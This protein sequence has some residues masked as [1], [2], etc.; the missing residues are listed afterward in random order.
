MARLKDLHHV[1]PFFST[2]AGGAPNSAYAGMGETDGV[3]ASTN[4]PG[5]QDFLGTISTMQVPQLGVFTP[6]GKL[7]QAP[8]LVGY[9]VV[10]LSAAPDTNILAFEFSQVAQLLASL[11]FGQ[12]GFLAYISTQP[13]SAESVAASLAGTPYKLFDQGIVVYSQGDPGGIPAM[14]FLYWIQLRDPGDTSG[15]SGGVGVAAQSLGATL[16]F[17]QQVPIEQTT[18]RAPPTADVTTVAQVQFPSY[19]GGASPPPPNGPLVNGGDAAS[20]GAAAPNGNGT[21]VASSSGVSGGAI[22]AGILAAVAGF[23][24]A[25]STSKK[26]R[27]R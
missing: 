7:V 2:D 8:T 3:P 14:S 22:V 16:V 23:A 4:I 9:D 5:L 26:R 24:I 12:P 21:A 25:R 13:L 10:P 15:G 11:G 18:S 27:S 20:N 1:G 6:W 19:F 17:A